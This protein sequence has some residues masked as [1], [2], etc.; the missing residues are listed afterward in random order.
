MHYLRKI[1]GLLTRVE[2]GLLVLFLGLMTGLTFLNICLR[3][4]SVHTSS[5][6]AN[7]LLRHLDW[8]QPLVRLM[9]LWTTFLGASLI[10]RESRHIRIDIFPTML[11]GAKKKFWLSCI[12]ALSFIVTLFLAGSSIMYL[13]HEAS[14]GEVSLFGLPTWVIHLILPLGFL[15]MAFR[16]FLNLLGSASHVGGEPWKGKGRLHS[17]QDGGPK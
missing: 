13:V 8:S 11:R 16:F 4:L 14:Y 12:W 3:I 17:R 1:E 10:T 15:T 2:S 7:L 5:T 9:V 6:L